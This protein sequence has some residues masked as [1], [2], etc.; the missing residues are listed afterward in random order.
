MVASIKKL[1]FAMAVN[2]YYGQTFKKSGISFLP[3]MFCHGRLQVYVVLPSRE[4]QSESFP[5]PKR[6]NTAI[7]VVYK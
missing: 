2:K 1:P 7:N 5:S 6:K 4:V 3:I